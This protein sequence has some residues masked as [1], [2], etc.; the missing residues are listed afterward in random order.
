MRINE[1]VTGAEVRVSDDEQLITI[2]DLRGIIT[3]ANDAFVKIS[4]YERKE[5]VGQN[6]NLI[7]H[8]DMPP[9][10][11][12]DL[13]D[14][15]GKGRSWKGLVKNRCKNGD[16]YWVDAYVTPI[17]RDGKIVEYQSVRIAATQKSISRAEKLY[18]QWRQ[19]KT[20][21]L[22]KRPGLSL[23]M[24]VLLTGSLPA[25]I[26][27]AILAGLGQGWVSGALLVAGLVTTGLLANQLKGL[28]RLKTA[29][30]RINASPVMQF[31][32]TGRQDELGAMDF[33]LRTRSSE[34]R[35]V[36]SRLHN[37]SSYLR[38]SKSRSDEK[39]HEAFHYLEEQGGRVT[40][41]RSAMQE[42]MQSLESVMASTERTAA[43]ASQ[44]QSATREGQE[45]IAE[46]AEAIAS[47]SEEL[48]VAKK[49]VA[50]LAASSE[51]IGTVIDVITNVAE[52]T[53][54]LALNAAIEAARA[55]EA[56]RGFAVV[57][58]EVRGLAQ[59]THESTQQVRTIINQLQEDTQGS[60]AAI[61]KGV[62][63]SQKTVNLAEDMRTSLEEVLSAVAQINQ[64]AV[65]VSDMTHQQSALSEQTR[66]QV[67]ELAELAEKSVTAGEAARH[68]S[69]KLDNQ[70]ANL[71]LLASN[72]IDSLNNQ[73]QQ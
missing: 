15:L 12:K 4:G 39:L 26:A 1:P 57:A 30:E 71:H 48:E 19:G 69:D 21:A 24:K 13:W 56:G 72:F 33:A 40:E 29:A 73:R 5:L 20:P 17:R 50:S 53:N 11:F 25:L 34:L 44:S 41:I 8:P 36:V 46:V 49:Q 60:V 63:A 67:G 31:L 59:R 43:A 3:F 35:A 68:E 64:L 7:R 37:N 10:A 32:Y 45:R 22:I 27:A 47:Q 6:H 58:D 54:L 16:H 61:E 28:K 9:E 51:Q 18:R 52:Q 38:R 66:R 14:T 65:E 70:V 62:Q 42:Q 23:H 55:G 2:T